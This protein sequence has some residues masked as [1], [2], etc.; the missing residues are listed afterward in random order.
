MSCKNN[1]LNDLQGQSVIYPIHDLDQ[2]LSHPRHC[3]WL[4]QAILQD[5]PGDHLWSGRITV[6]GY[7]WGAKFHVFHG[8]FLSTKIYAYCVRVIRLCHQNV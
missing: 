8:A 7:F 4:S 2:I 6:Q 1:F 3:A 5:Y